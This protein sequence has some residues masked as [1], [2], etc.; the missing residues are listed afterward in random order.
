MSKDD[1]EKAGTVDP[2]LNDQYDKI[3]DALSKK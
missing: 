2:Y 3:T 1:D